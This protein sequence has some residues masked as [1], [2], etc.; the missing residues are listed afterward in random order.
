[1]DGRGNVVQLTDANQDTV[2]D[3]RYSAFGPLLA[4]SGAEANNN[5]YR[6]S[7]KEYHSQPGLY[8]YEYRFYS[9]GLGRWINRDPI[10]EKG[11]L[12][13]YQFVANDPMSKYD[14]NGLWTI[15]K[16]TSQISA[17]VVFAGGS[18]LVK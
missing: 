14:P 15:C 2:A 4:S 11:G 16:I 8:D 7:T 3:Y 6:F 1:Y 12:N 10:Q 18:I 13:I 5:P 9:P 17:M